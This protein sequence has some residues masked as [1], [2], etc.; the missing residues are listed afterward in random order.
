MSLF[1][2]GHNR[3]LIDEGYRATAGVLDSLGDQMEG[4]IYP[5]K[6]VEVRVDRSRCIGCGMCA[7]HSP[8]VFRM[9]DDQRAEV[10]APVQTWSPLDG[11]YVRNCPTYAISVRLA[12]PGV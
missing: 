5:K 1:A 8:A 3:E 6:R 2:F 12:P 7:M 4:G 10:I 9:A 11:A